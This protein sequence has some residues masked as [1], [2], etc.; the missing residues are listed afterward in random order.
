VF[1]L[2]PARLKRIFPDRT[3]P[4]YSGPLL[5]VGHEIC[6]VLSLAPGVEFVVAGRTY[7]N[8]GGVGLDVLDT[9]LGPLLGVQADVLMGMPI[10]RQ[11]RTLCIDFPRCK[12]W[13][14]WLEPD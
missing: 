10:M 14:D 12:M 2:S 11:M 9:L 3:I 8:Y 1:A 6:P 5:G 4:S 7:A 13:V